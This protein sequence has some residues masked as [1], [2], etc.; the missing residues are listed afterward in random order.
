MANVSCFVTLINHTKRRALTKII[1]CYLATC[2]GFY[3][4]SQVWSLCGQMRLK[5]SAHFH[6]FMALRQRFAWSV[7]VRPQ[8]QAKS[9]NIHQV[10]NHRRSCYV[11]PL[12]LSLLSSFSPSPAFSLSLSFASLRD[13]HQLIVQK[14]GVLRRHLK[15]LSQFVVLSGDSGCQSALNHVRPQWLLGREQCWSLCK[16]CCVFTQ[17]NVP[18]TAAVLIK[19]KRQHCCEQTSLSL[20]ISLFLS[21]PFQCVF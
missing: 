11:L 14:D 8:A 16:R 4:L 5:D 17:T 10:K 6:S 9:C 7:R 1:K 3:R 2:F 15:I 12:P 18:P 21:L 19:A 13:A 20:P